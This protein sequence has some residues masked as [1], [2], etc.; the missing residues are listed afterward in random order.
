M[1]FFASIWS[2]P[3]LPSIMLRN[4]QNWTVFAAYWKTQ[5]D[6]SSSTQQHVLLSASRHWSFHNVDIRNSPEC[7]SFPK[8]GTKPEEAWAKGF[9]SGLTNKQSE[10]LSSFRKLRQRLSDC[11]LP[12]TCIWNVNH[13]K[14]LYSNPDRDR[15]HE[16]KSFPDI[17]HYTYSYRSRY[18][19]G[20]IT[21]VVVVQLHIQVT[22]TAEDIQT[23]W[24]F[25]TA[26]EIWY[27][28][29][30]GP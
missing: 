22:N 19:T 10:L 3:V 29:I 7:F 23:H 1:Y 28:L 20:F 25:T 14:R 16:M 27:L 30:A 8:E 21:W 9:C 13:C 2:L 26:E 17:T 24:T 4:Q 5:Q 18:Q 12:S 6:W 11:L 15:L